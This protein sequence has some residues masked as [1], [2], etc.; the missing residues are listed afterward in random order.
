M[1]RASTSIARRTAL[2]IVCV[3]ISGCWDGASTG[4]HHLVHLAAPP[5]DLYEPIATS[6]Y[7]LDRPGEERS[8][9]LEHRYRDYYELGI[10]SRSGALPADYRFDGRVVAELST[11]DG[12]VRTLESD[13]MRSGVFA[14]GGLDRYAKIA[15]L[16][17]ELPVESGAATAN[18][19]LRVLDPDSLPSGARDDVELYVAVSGVP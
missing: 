19:T 3:G 16:A 14:P 8:F 7:F 6:D 15:L 9:R 5:D 12:R 18:L 17:F 13:S 4:L 2:G 1:T 10:R 11:P